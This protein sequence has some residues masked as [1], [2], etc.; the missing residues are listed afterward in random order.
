MKKIFLMSTVLTGVLA[1]SNFSTTANASAFPTDEVLLFN[2]NPNS[3]G[4]STS[5]PMRL[6][7]SSVKEVKNMHIYFANDTTEGPSDSQFIYGDM[8]RDIFE[9][10]GDYTDY[11][12]KKF[13]LTAADSGSMYANLRYTSD[14]LQRDLS[15]LIELYPEDEKVRNAANSYINMTTNATKDGSALYYYIK[16]EEMENAYYTRFKAED[17]FTYR[18]MVMGYYEAQNKM[19]YT[20]QHPDIVWHEAGHALLDAMRPDL[21][22]DSI[23]AG[24]LHEACGDTNSFFTI[25]SYESLRHQVLADTQGDLKKPNFVAHMAE[26][27]GSSVLYADNGLRD[28]DDD[29][30]VGDVNYQVHD[31]SRVLSG[32]IYDIVIK[33]FN[34]QRR[35]SREAH[36]DILGDVSKFLRTHWIY[37]TTQISADPSFTEIGTTLQNS[38]P[39]NVAVNGHNL[40]WQS[41]VTEAFTDARDITLDGT[42]DPYDWDNLEGQDWFALHGGKSHLAKDKE[43]VKG[44][45]KV[46]SNHDNE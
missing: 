43:R 46:V 35:V 28:L 18:L 25:L 3:T 8:G 40:P 14:L 21:F 41:Y 38:L 4:K 17:G 34:D 23:K 1:V 19:H 16:G 7:D 30:N 9:E 31:L 11:S 32:A 12:L 26:R 15:N 5:F 22:S 24:V 36:S 6:Q 27:F 44:L 2:L 20:A 13:R 10:S 33:A 42:P 37:T 39:Q 45:K 29:V